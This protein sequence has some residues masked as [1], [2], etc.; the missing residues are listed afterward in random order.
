MPPST[1]AAPSAT[2]IRAEAEAALAR[3]LAQALEGRVDSRRWALV[4][5]L[6][7]RGGRVLRRRPRW[8]LLLRLL[9]L[10]LLLLLAAAQA[11]HAV[12]DR[13]G[14]A[15]IAAEAPAL[16]VK[17]LLA[18]RQAERALIGARPDV[19]GDESW[20]RWNRQLRLLPPVAMTWSITA[21]WATAAGCLPAPA[22][23]TLGS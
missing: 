5:E 19:P 11:L 14:L 18:R 15:V 16:T 3:Q 6:R 23:G 7:T 1:S 21:L 9:W 10:P 20:R 13:A 4:G 8:R 2:A 17:R 12:A 22:L